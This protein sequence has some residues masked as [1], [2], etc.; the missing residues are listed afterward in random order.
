MP[1]PTG[2]TDDDGGT[3][4]GLPT[5][6]PARELLRRIDIGLSTAIVAAFIT[7]LALFVGYRQAELAQQSLR[8]STLPILDVSAGYASP[9]VTGRIVWEARVR[10]VGTGTAHLV[11]V[12]PLVD[13]EVPTD[14]SVFLD[15]FSTANA[16]SSAEETR[17]AATGYLLPGDAVAPLRLA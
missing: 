16:R 13:G 2:I 9:E 5:R 15:S 7:L 3:L 14:L 6:R 1:L 12:T 17:T 4:P 8:A 10:N 11:T